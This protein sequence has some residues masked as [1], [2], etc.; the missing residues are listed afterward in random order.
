MYLPLAS[1]TLHF[2][3]AALCLSTLR[4]HPHCAAPGL[5]LSTLRG[6]PHCE[7][8]A[9]PSSLRGPGAVPLHPARPEGIY[10]N[11][12]PGRGGRGDT[13]GGGQSRVC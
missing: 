12:L 3:P 9:R 4:G 1:A 5:C 8:H 10:P 7:A 11:Q 6:P 13:Q 2:A